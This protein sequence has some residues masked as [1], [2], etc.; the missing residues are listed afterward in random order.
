MNIPTCWICGAIANSAEH[1]VKASDFKSVFRGVTQ[2]TPAYRHSKEGRNQPIRGPKAEILKFAP[3]LCRNCNNALTQPHDL[4]WQ[5]FSDFVRNA[6]PIIPDGNRIPLQRIFPSTVKESMLNVHFYFLKLLGCHAIEHKIPL[7]VNHFATCLK[8][9][10]PCQALRLIFVN[11][12]VGLSRHKIQ[13]G[14]I[15]AL[16]IGGK[17]VSA[18]WFYRIEKLT[19]VVSYCESGHP[20]LT[21]D[22][23]WHPD[24]I[25]TR[26][27]LQSNVKRISN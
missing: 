2:N 12:P 27:V 4:A 17:T 10:I 22:R 7:P 1:M 26:V 20:R 18:S 5:R 19:V 16:N 9:S 23:G 3:S 11:T 13:V 14:A 21:V 15:E 8:H 6:R 24:D 25:S